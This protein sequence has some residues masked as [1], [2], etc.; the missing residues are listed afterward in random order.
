MQ[1]KQLASNAFLAEDFFSQ[2]FEI[3]PIT[4]TEFSKTLKTNLKTAHSPSVLYLKG[5]KKILEEKSIA[6]VG[7]RD[8][9][10][11]SLQ[12]T[13]KIAKLASKE[14]KVVDI[15]SQDFFLKFLI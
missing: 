14:Y 13:D 7:S 12:F 1:K 10:E 2:G 9:S 5:N 8:A 11:I 4:S 6:I 15:N 3:I